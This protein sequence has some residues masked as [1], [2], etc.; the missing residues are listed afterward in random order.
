MGLRLP[1][2]IED[3]QRD[4]WDA[5]SDR[6]DREMRR[7]TLRD[8]ALQPMIRAAL[9]ARDVTVSEEQSEAWHRAAWIG[10]SRFGVQLYPDTIDVLRE[11]RER[12]VAIGVNTNRPCTSDMLADD[13]ADM[14]LRGL[15]DATVC[16]GDVGYLKPH[17]ATFERIIEL[18]GLPV[19][20][21]VMVGDSLEGDV[22]AAKA[23]GM[24]A[25]WKLNGRHDVDGIDEADFV[26]H[27][28]NELLALPIFPAPHPTADSAVPHE[29]SNAGRY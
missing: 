12:G 10:A 17:A 24:I 13:L 11:L 25:V 6:W 16:S 27:D 20:Q 18:L 28:L 23:Q 21:L 15:A 26:I 4:V 14:G 2:T 29:D 7:G 5:Y 19:D 1:C 22:R 9:A 3:I 8:P